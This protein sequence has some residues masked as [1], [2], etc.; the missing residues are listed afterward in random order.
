[1]S[2]PRPRSPSTTVAIRSDSLSRSSAAPRTI[3]SPSAKQPS[4]AT[5]GSSSIASGTSCG[6]DR[7]PLDR[8][9]RTSRSATGSSAPNEPS[10]SRSPSTIAPIRSRI[11]RKPARVQ[12]TPTLSSTS[13]DPRTSTPAA[14]RNAAED[15]SP[16]TSMRSSS[17]SSALPT[18]V[19]VTPPVR[20]ASRRTGRAGA[21]QH[22]ARCGRGS[23]AGSITV[24]PS[25]SRPASSTHDLTCALATGS[26]YS[27]PVSGAPWT[28]NGRKPSVACLD[29][30]SHLTQRLGDTVN[31]AAPDRVVSVE[32]EA[33]AVLER[34]PAREQAHQ[35][36]RVA[37]VDRSGWQLRV[38][39]A[40]S[41][42]QELVVAYLDDRA[43]LADRRQRRVRV[44][45][46]QIVADPDRL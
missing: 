16:G 25:V 7:R 32:R 17:S 4:S 12:L 11:R 26:S 36:A 46:V 6:I 22:A 34:E 35:R 8:A 33:R 13:R 18:T 44:R 21:Q 43:K 45:G 1:M 19:A 29:P 39:K 20:S 9:L 31:G 38:A 30:G 5:S 40:A 10:G 27:I 14:I 41:A 15:R 42:D 2:A 28:V 24:V 37:D 3:V 23:G